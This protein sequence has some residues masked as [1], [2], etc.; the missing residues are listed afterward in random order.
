[1]IRQRRREDRVMLTCAMVAAIGLWSPAV[2]CRAQPLTAAAANAPAIRIPQ[3]T[4]LISVIRRLATERN[5]VIA[6]AVADARVLQ[7]TIPPGA[8]SIKA[9]SDLIRA[10]L[11]AD[12]CRTGAGTITFRSTLPA[13]AYK[14]YVPPTLDFEL[15][16]NLRCASFFQS[17]SPA[18]WQQLATRHYTLPFTSFTEKQQSLIFDMVVRW[19]HYAVNG[20][21]LVDMPKSGFTVKLFSQSDMNLRT[22]EGNFYAILLEHRP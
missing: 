11:K 14:L 7:D 21:S 22:P 15:T 10:R 19:K 2:V 5:C 13:P 3:A 20:V 18:Q 4:S 12:E 17:L 16:G 8:Y 9:I 1:L 6:G